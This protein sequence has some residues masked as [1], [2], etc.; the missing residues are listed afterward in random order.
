MPDFIT[1]REI[2]AAVGK[3]SVWRTA[4]SVNAANKGVLLTSE[5]LGAKAPTFIQDESLGLTDLRELIKTCEGMGGSVGGVLRY[6]T[7]DLLLACA[8]GASGVPACVEGSAYSHVYSVADNIDDCFVTLAMKK[9]DTTHGI[10]EVPSATVT[11]FTIGGTL[12]QLGTITFN[13][14][15]NK[16]EILSP[17][18]TS[19]ANV[20]YRSRVAQAKFDSRSKIRMNTQSGGALADSDKVYPHTFE[21]T[22]ARPF[23]ESREVGYSDAGQ[24]VQ[25]G[26]TD[27]RV[28]LGFDK[29]N[30]DTFLDAIANETDQKMDILFEGAIISG[31]TRYTLRI[32]IPKI[33][34]LSGDAPVG[35]PG[36]IPHSVEGRCLAVAAAPTGMA[37]V[38]DPISI[39]MI[40][41]LSTSP[42]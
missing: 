18:N 36:K 19:L 34:W 5:G 27:V 14:M 29:Y 39:Y 2:I 40:N 11:G 17:V 16:L 21:L 22:F 8:L 38:T 37:G 33:T 24:P 13:L 3:G 23:E 20:T 42:I 12:C 1:G 25:N 28:K 7:W 41:T 10:W 31:A 15:G 32:D 26:Y 4:V 35:G 6:E 30:L 9:A